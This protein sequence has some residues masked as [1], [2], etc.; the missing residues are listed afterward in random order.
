M[1]NYSTEISVIIVVSPESMGR[2][3]LYVQNCTWPKAAT[4]GTDKSC[5][6][7]QRTFADIDSDMCYSTPWERPSHT[8]QRRPASLTLLILADVLRDCLAPNDLR[9]REENKDCDW[10]CSARLSDTGKFSSFSWLF[11]TPFLPTFQLPVVCYETCE[12][13]RTPPPR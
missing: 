4:T 1:T 13:V 6:K 12:E 8:E 9:Y 11:N 7:P 2:F 5:R 3:F 10:R